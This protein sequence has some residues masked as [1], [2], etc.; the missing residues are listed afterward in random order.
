MRTLIKK[1]LSQV[2][3]HRPV[4]PAL[5]R[6]RQEAQEFKG[7]PQLPRKLEASLDFTRLSQ[8]ATKQEQENS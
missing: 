1:I 2:W 4:V 6:W 8:T 7:K 3:E 5:E